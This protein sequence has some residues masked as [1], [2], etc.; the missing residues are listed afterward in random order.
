MN[1]KGTL[2][3]RLQRECILVPKEDKIASISQ[4]GSREWVFTLKYI[5][6]DGSAIDAFIILKG[7]YFKMDIFDRATPGMTIATSEK[8]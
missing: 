4:D 2:M 8:G 7:I 5:C 1:E 3:G 6:A